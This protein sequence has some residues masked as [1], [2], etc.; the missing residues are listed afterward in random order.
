MNLFLS[1][2]LHLNFRFVCGKKCRQTAR[3]SHWLLM[4][5]VLIIV[6]L[7]GSNDLNNEVYLIFGSSKRWAAKFFIG[8][9]QK[10]KNDNNNYY[11]CA[12]IKTSLAT[13]QAPLRSAAIKPGKRRPLGSGGRESKNVR[14]AGCPRESSCRQQSTANDCRK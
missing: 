3:H 10:W 14:L 12:R 13:G 8:F 4:V 5:I 11:N 6:A 1:L 7:C 2:A 9:W